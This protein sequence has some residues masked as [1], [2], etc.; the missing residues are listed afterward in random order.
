VHTGCKNLLLFDID[1]RELIFSSDGTD[2]TKG[3][4]MSPFGTSA[5]KYLTLGG[6]LL[7]FS[8]DIF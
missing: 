5:K 2:N 8:N 7:T 3:I 6:D 4:Y 1:G